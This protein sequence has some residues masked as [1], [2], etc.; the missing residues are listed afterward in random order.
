MQDTTTA[1]DWVSVTGHAADRWH[2]RTDNPGIGP[3]VAWQTAARCEP[4]HL[5]GDEIRYHAG[6]DCY[7]VAKRG[8][9]VTVVEADQPGEPT[10]GAGDSPAEAAESGVEA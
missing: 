9:L 6:I 1:D 7:L 5:Y 3:V 4:S 2:E 8:R 10:P